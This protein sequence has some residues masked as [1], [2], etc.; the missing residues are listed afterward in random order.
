MPVRRSPAPEPVEDQAADPDDPSR[1]QFDAWIAGLPERLET[2]PELRERGERIKRDVLRS[3]GLRDW[4]S[5][6]W[7]KAKEALRALQSGYAVCI[8]VEGALDPAAPRVPFAGQEITYSSFAARA[9][10]RL[11]LP[12]VFYAP[13]WENGRIVNTLEMMPAV[14]PGEDVEVY[15][16][17]WQQAYLGHLREHLSGAPENLRLSGGIWRHVRPVDRSA[18]PYDAPVADR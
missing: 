3:A 12:S 5:S 8:A 9:A 15:A 6:L 1:R 10:H 18:Q 14:R 7:Q 17:R 4:S 13:R 11:G 2:S 16:L